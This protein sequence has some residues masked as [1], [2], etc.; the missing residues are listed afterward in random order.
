M[1]D[2]PD[3]YISR[4]ENA[5]YLD[6]IAERDRLISYIQSYEKK[7]IAG[8]RSGA[9]WGMNPQPNVFYQVYLEYLA[10]LCIL[11]QRKYN[12]DYVWGDRSLHEDAKQ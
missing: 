12:S 11:M 9:E 8:D 3:A 6:L 1:M 4:F 5:E 2:S 10:E 7:E